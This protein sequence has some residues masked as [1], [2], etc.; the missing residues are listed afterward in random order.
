MNRSCETRSSVAS[1]SARTAAPAGG[2]IT[3]WSQS[4]SACGRTKIGDLSQPA[5]QFL[6]SF[7]HVAPLGSRVYRRGARYTAVGTNV[8]ALP[9]PCLD[10]DLGRGPADHVQ[11]VRLAEPVWPRPAEARC[12]CQHERACLGGAGVEG[13][14]FDRAA[15]VDV[16]AEDELGAC[17]GEGSQHC[18][19]VL[20]RELARGAPGSA[21]EV[22]MA[23]DD[24]ECVR[25]RRRRASSLTAS[26]RAASRR[27]PWWRQGRA[28]LSPQT[29]ALA[30]R[31]TGSVVPKTAANTSQGRVTR[32]GSV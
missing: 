25:R 16:A 4:S 14:P 18:V 12:R 5:S 2:I 13:V 30:V 17:G 29:T 8:V 27:P 22:V 23:D 31:N 6:E 24:A 26:R 19:A 9:D 21:R 15:L 20:E 1:R 28:E 7:L 10:R 3:I 32:A 11:A